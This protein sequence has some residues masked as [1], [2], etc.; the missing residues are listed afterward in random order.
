MRGGLGLLLAVHGKPLPLRELYLET[1]VGTLTGLELLKIYPKMRYGSGGEAL[2]TRSQSFVEVDEV[3][4]SKFLLAPT[5]RSSTS[6]KPKRSGLSV[7]SKLG[8]Y[9]ELSELSSYGSRWLGDLV[10]SSTK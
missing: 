3:E 7:G 2:R 10:I 5:P 6:R 8:R 4:R 1:L 9:H